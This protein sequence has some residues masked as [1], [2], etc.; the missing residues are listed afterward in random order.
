MSYSNGSDKNNDSEKKMCNKI[1]AR[2]STLG[3]LSAIVDQLLELLNIGAVKIKHDPL[4]YKYLGESA[5]VNI[6][7]PLVLSHVGPLITFSKDAKVLYC[8]WSCFS[9]A[10]CAYL[11]N[12]C[13]FRR[14]PLTFW[15]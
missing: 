6:L 10:L 9:M 2:E 14:V 4:V 3:A 15:T 5:I 11:R 1:N 8:Y 12:L 7:M 13:A